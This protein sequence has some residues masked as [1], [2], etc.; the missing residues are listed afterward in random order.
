MGGVF[1]VLGV[2]L[3]CA[4]PAMHHQAGALSWHGTRMVLAWRGGHAHST[5][6]AL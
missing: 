3:W 1:V 2:V 4:P 5:F 6:V